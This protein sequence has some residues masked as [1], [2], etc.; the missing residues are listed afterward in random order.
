MD[1]LE[2]AV[3]EIKV[4]EGCRLK[5]YRCPAGVP[6]IGWGETLGVKMGMVWTQAYA[7]SRL[8]IRVAQFMAAVLK[9]CPI[10]HLEPPQR[11]AAC[12]SLAY[13]IGIGAFRTS[14]VCRLTMR[15]E[16]DRA[17]DSF[18]LWNKG[19]GRVLKGL[20][21]RRAAERALYLRA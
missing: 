10:L 11:T 20:V 12:T 16:F 15:Q 21:I 13:N 5:A 6:T 3:E 8:R 18:K 9:A 2:M 1:A 17:A 7:D 4:S 19:G 14:S